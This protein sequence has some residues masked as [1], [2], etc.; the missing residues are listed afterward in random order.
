MV[1]TEQIDR[2]AHIHAEPSQE[3]W[4]AGIWS[5]VQTMHL[6]DFAVV[7]AQP[8][9]ASRPIDR[10]P[11]GADDTQ[12]HGRQVQVVGERAR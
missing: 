7:K 6:G 9:G 11:C 1:S 5:S 2:L 4:H 8:D 10:F 12:A 3:S